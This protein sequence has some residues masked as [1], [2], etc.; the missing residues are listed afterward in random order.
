[1]NCCHFRQFTNDD[2]A[3]IQYSTRCCQIS[4]FKRCHKEPTTI[5]RRSESKKCQ[6]RISDLNFLVINF[7]GG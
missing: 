5:T 6:M 2:R 4:N 3:T 7:E 1:M